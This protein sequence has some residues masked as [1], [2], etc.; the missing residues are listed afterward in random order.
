M[1]QIGIYWDFFDFVFIDYLS[2]TI[3]RRPTLFSVLFPY[4][5]YGLTMATR[6]DGGRFKQGEGPRRARA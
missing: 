2:L 4:F 1:G 6:R 5:P 3:Q